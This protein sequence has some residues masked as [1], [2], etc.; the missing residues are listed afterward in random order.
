MYNMLHGL[1]DIKTVTLDVLTI[2]KKRN[3]VLSDTTT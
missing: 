1:S 3:T 2:V